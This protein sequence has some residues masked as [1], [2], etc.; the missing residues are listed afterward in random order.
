MK[1]KALAFSV[2]FVWVAV[3]VGDNPKVSAQD[4]RSAIKSANEEAFDTNDFHVESA[5]VAEL[6]PDLK[7]NGNVFQLAT[8]TADGLFRVTVEKGRSISA[9]GGLAVV[10]RGTGQVMLSVADA[11]GDTV[12]DSLSYSKVDR[13]GRI[14][15]TVVDYEA[16]GQPDLRL[17][18][19]SKRTEF[20]HGDRWYEVEQRE[21][22]VRGIVVDG[23]FLELNSNNNRFAIRVRE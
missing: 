7:P 19:D 13:T 9:G 20:W 18:F 16:D 8:V 23:E 10:Q 12:L 11:D 17:D 5:E 4:L 1:T 14:L 2:L 22:G 6:G 21:D 3:S 15:S